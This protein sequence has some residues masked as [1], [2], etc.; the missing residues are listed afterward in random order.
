MHAV[1]FEGQPVG[2]GGPGEVFHKLKDSWKR[3]VGIDFVAQA[4]DYATR[5]DAWEEKQRRAVEA[6]PRSR[7][8]D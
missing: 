1:S 3:Q 5:M 7:I 8:T 6:S 2:D 4:K